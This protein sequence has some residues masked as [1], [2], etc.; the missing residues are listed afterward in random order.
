MISLN[1]VHSTNYLIAKNGISYYSAKQNLSVKFV[2]AFI[3][4]L[5]IKC[6]K[7]QPRDII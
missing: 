3:E 6:P 2:A 5:M 7:N 4:K 1:C